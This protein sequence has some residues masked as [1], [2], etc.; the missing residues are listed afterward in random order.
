MVN[1][2]GGADEVGTGGRTSSEARGYRRLY[3]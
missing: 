2:G 1:G 3:L